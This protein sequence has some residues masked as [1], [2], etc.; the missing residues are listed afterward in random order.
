MTTAQ[1]DRGTGGDGRAAGRPG[2]H[3]FLNVDAHL[4]DEERKVRAEVRSF[5]EERIRPNIK[6]WW[7][8]AHFPRELVPEMG[9][10]GVLGMHLKGYGCAGKSAVAYGLACMELEAGDSGLRT[11]VSVQGSLAM[12]AIH[13]FGSEEQKERWLPPMARGEAIGCFGLTEPTAG[14]DPAS[15]KTFARRDGSDWVLNGEKRWIG[16]GTIADIAV[17]WARTD[18]E[19]NP[20]RGFLI[21]TDTPGFSAKDI[22]GKLSMRASVQ[23]DL[24]FEDVLLP[25]GAMLPGAEGLKGPFA[26]LNEARYGIVWGSMGAARDSFECALEYATEREQFGKPVAAFQLTQEKLVN[27]MLEVEKGTLLALHLGRMKDEGTLR[28]EQISFGKLNNVREAIKV[29]REARTILGGNGVTLDYPIMR[30]ANNLE[31]VRTYE[32]TDEVHTLILGNA[33]TGIP[34][35]R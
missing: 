4:S 19:G 32:G 14:S 6:D 27:M 11:F 22:T 18:E 31:S 7:E 34:A 28:S 12:S 17:V 5:V 20:V 1:T 33:I 3:D 30:H 24:S 13:K 25:G 16:M 21:P 35:F 8:R 29:A 26:C 2:P 15:M 23:C 10:L 9:A